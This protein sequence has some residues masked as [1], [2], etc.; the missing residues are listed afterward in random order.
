MKRSIVLVFIINV[1]FQI[2]GS[3]A[4]PMKPVGPLTIKGTIQKIS[5]YPEEF[6]K[7]IPGLSGSAGQDRTIPAHYRLGIEGTWKNSG[8][9]APLTVHKGSIDLRIDHPEND[10]FLIGNMN[11]RI[12]GYRETGDEGGI[13]SS[14]EKI[15]ILET[16]AKLRIAD[17]SI[18]DGWVKLSVDFKQIFDW[19][20]IKFVSQKTFPLRGGARIPHE[21]KFGQHE[22]G[23]FSWRQ[24]DY[25]EGGKYEVEDRYT[26]EAKILGRKKIEGVFDTNTNL[27]EFDGLV[28]EPFIKAPER[29]VYGS[30]DLKTWKKISVAGKTPGEYKWP[31]QVE[32]KLKVELGSSDFYRMKVEED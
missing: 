21:I 20:K 12:I 28:Y 26:V 23:F 25:I 1:L 18:D 13:R 29:S 9:G 31:S 8:E 24:Y 15:E 17:I 10:S 11:V 5:W 3:H 19:E 14:L 7:G 27:L 30:K 16:K 4:G 32:L 6:R 22:E 2:S